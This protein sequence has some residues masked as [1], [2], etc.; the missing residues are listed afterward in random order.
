MGKLKGADLT[1]AMSYAFELTKEARER[2][3]KKA[4]EKRPRFT[5]G[6]RA[7]LNFRRRGN[8]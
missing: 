6:F 3:K 7:A 1:D 8:R 2:M 4:E 5:E